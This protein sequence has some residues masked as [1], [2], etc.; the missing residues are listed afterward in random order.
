MASRETRGRKKAKLNPAG[1][2]AA[3]AGLPS[4]DGPEIVLE[5][6]VLPEPERMHVTEPAPNVEEDIVDTAT[7]PSLR[8][9]AGKAAVNDNKPGASGQHAETSSDDVPVGPA[10][11]NNKGGVRKDQ[12]GRKGR[13]GATGGGPGTRGRRADKGLPAPGYELPP[14]ET[15]QRKTGRSRRSPPPAQVQGHDDGGLEEEDAP[16]MDAVVKVFCTHTEP[17]YSLPWQ[18]K[19]QFSSNSS[20]FII[21]GRRVLTN[22]H[23]VEHHTQVKVKKRG[24]DTKFL[25]TVLAIGTECDIAM[26]T[27]EDDDFW[28]GVTPLEFGSLPRLQDS[29]T[30]VGYPIGGD[31]ISVTSGVVSRIEVTSY[32]HGSSE[33]LGVQIDA[34]INAGNSGGPAFNESGNCVG[35]AFQSLKNED[36]ENIGYVIPT[37]VINHFITDFERTG[38]YTGFPILGIEWQKMENPQ[39]R[40]ALGMT[41]HQKGVRVRRVEPT[42]PSAEQLQ[43]SDILLSFDGVDVANDGTVPFRRGERIAFSYLVSQRYTGETARLTILREGREHQV[44]VK[45]GSHNRLVPVHTGGKPPSY[46][47]V[48][49]LVFTPVSVPYL[50]SE[51]GKNFEFDAPVKL[52]DKMMHVMADAPDQQ[53]VV[54]SQVLVADINIGYEEIV[55]TQ[56]LRFNGTRVNNLKHLAAMVEAAT[57]PFLRFDLEY[58]QV[59]VLETA[60]AKAATPS[61]LKTHRIPSARSEDLNA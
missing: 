8:R 19:R 23:S 31:T 43:A 42:A 28:E 48:A 11:K 38:G 10:R 17:N 4:L 24:S 35:I 50:A 51:Y 16:F 40:K 6:E 52:L 41:D 46:Y 54:V 18:R 39:L 45:L 14:R 34:A 22:A 37:P 27:V 5:R 44:Q 55:N 57:A 60:A 25:A 13:S 7:P 47:I 59:M 26:L 3:L 30:V 20:G 58:D 15:P 56:V 9:R 29:V 49:G 36:A 32:A 61:I 53:V 12:D 2:D 33:L 1:E 21:G